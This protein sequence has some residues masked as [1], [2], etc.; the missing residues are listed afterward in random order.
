MVYIASAA[1]SVRVEQP[2]AAETASS[3]KESWHG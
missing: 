2:P 1:K 3:D